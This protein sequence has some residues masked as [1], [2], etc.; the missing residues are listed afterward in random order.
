MLTCTVVAIWQ[1][2]R[3][4]GG[5]LNRKSNSSGEDS[6]RHNHPPLSQHKTVCSG[7][8]WHTECLMTGLSMR[9]W[10]LYLGQPWQ[11]CV[12]CLLWLLVI[13]DRGYDRP[14][15]GGVHQCWHLVLEATSESGH[16]IWPCDSWTQSL[17]PMIASSDVTSVSRT[18]YG[19]CM[20]GF[21]SHGSLKNG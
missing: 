16:S 21:G 18:Q 2:L 7:K 19:I 5:E 17:R 13:Y 20:P 1:T 15:D 9:L 3:T 10:P 11:M 6:T 4:E 8:M 14:I 12:Q